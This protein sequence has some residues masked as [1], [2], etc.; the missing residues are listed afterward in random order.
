M[1]EITI[2]Y[3]PK[4]PMTLSDFLGVAPMREAIY[5]YHGK[6]PHLKYKGECNG[7]KAISGTLLPH[8][9]F[10]AVL[11]LSP[12][13]SCTAMDSPAALGIP[14]TTMERRRCGRQKMSLRATIS[15]QM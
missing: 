2:S 14:Q 13:D 15:R 3:C 1:D 10:V 4:N 5:R 6:P 12:E 8:P 9:L 11:V 7:M